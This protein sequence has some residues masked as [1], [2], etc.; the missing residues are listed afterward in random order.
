[1]AS[2]K[3][4]KVVCNCCKKPKDEAEFD[5]VALRHATKGANCKECRDKREAVF[6]RTPGGKAHRY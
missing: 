1:M 6:K 5:A 4:E 2:L 3:R